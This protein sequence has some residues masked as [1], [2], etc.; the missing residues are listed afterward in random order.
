MRRNFNI[1]TVLCFFNMLRKTDSCLGRLAHCLHNLF[2]WGFIFVIYNIMKIAASPID[3]VCLECHSTDCISQ[4]FDSE[5]H[6]VDEY[7]RC[8]RC[9]SYDIAY[10]DTAVFDE[11]WLRG[12]IKC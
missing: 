11:L 1:S 9:G 4:I 12:V 2:G 10:R 5:I 7:A 8:M 6:G 3:M